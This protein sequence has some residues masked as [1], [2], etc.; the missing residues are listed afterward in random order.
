MSKTSPLTAS[1]IEGI[2]SGYYVM[3]KAHD[4]GSSMKYEVMELLDNVYNLLLQCEF[5]G[6]KADAW[7]SIHNIHTYI[8]TPFLFFFFDVFGLLTAHTII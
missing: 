3:R 8:H 2:R 1:E 5:Y 6:D 7:V 4:D